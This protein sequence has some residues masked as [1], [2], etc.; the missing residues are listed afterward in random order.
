MSLYQFGAYTDQFGIGPGCF[1]VTN[2]GKHTQDNVFLIAKGLA[3]ESIVPEVPVVSDIKG[4][5]EKSKRSC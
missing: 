1:Q 3:D 5:I 4:I 2:L